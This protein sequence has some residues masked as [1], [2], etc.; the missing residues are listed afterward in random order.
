MKS[1][2]A[3]FRPYLFALALTSTLGVLATSGCVV[4]VAGAAGAGTVGYIRGELATTLNERYDRVIDAANTAV[5][6]LQFAKI[7][8]TKDAFTTVIVARTAEDKKIE[9]H[10]ERKADK[11]TDL[12]IRIG[13]FGDEEKSR[14]ILEHINAAL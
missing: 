3:I 14:A 2:L 1:K 10:I 8:Q 5:E 11:V 6:K 7:S 12:R 9:I 4:V 13:V